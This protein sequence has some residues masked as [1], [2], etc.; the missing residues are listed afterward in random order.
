MARAVAAAPT[1]RTSASARSDG[2][3]GA[4]RD[5]ALYQGAL[6]GVTHGVGVH[7]DLADGDSGDDRAPARPRHGRAAAACANVAGAWRMDQASTPKGKGKNRASGPPSA[8]GCG[9]GKHG[10][11]R[12]SRSDGPAPPTRGD[13]NGP[14]DQER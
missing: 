6:P 14:A 1:L 8:S 10:R 2:F 5:G 13:G 11:S 3:S 7:D 12:G 4:T 9:R